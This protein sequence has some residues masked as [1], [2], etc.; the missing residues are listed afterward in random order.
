[1]AGRMSIMDVVDHPYLATIQDQVAQA[2]Q[3]ANVDRGQ[4]RLGLSDRHMGFMRRI[5]AREAQAFA[6]GRPIKRGNGEV[7]CSPLHE[8]KNALK[9]TGAY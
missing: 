5:W 9:A 7:D 3:G 2:G 6:E 8:Q 1:M 4:E